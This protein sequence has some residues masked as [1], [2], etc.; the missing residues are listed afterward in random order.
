MS[1]D[2]SRLHR[3]GIALAIGVAITLIAGAAMAAARHPFDIDF[4]VFYESALA[5]RSGTDLYVTAR[6]FPNLNPPHFVI[7]RA[8]TEG[9]S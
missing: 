5:W 6:E 2:R 7:P 8:R 4:Y 3:R 1:I 9:P